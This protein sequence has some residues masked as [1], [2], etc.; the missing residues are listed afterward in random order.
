[1]VHPRPMKAPLSQVPPV[2]ASYYQFLNLSLIM[3]FV[4]RSSISRPH[5]ARVFRAYTRALSARG[6][7][8]ACPCAQYKMAEFVSLFLHFTAV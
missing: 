2:T 8:A 4:N 7:R 5:A 3:F 6:P 1:M